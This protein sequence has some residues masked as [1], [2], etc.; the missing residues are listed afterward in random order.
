MESTIS[1]IL[2]VVCVLGV[3]TCTGQVDPTGLAG[4]WRL[5]EFQSSDDAIGVVRPDSG[6]IYTMTLEQ[7]GKVSMQLNCNRAGG[8]WTA[9]P[10]NADNGT[11]GFGPLAMTRAFCPPPSLDTQIARHAQYIRSYVVRDGRLHLSLMAD[12]GIYVWTR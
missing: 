5:V 2:G 11:F 6:A 9:T 10:T 3:A 12:G 1:R 8:T 7:D 4:T